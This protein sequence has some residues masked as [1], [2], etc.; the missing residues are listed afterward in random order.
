MRVIDGKP[1]YS[2]VFDAWYK[3]IT[4][5]TPFALWKG[6]LPLF[7]RNGPQGIVMFFVYE[8]LTYFYRHYV[9]EPK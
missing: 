7:L 9:M 8:K 4:K 5:E 2:G 1:E 3:I 6:F